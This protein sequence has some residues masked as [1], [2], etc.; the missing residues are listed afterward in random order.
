MRLWINCDGLRAGERV[1][2]GNRRVLVGRILVDDRDV[3]LA[4]IRNVNQFFRRIPSQG[5]NARAVLDG[6]HDFA[7]VRINDHGRIVAT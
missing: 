3:A 7:R 1:D 6:R 2:R 4:A 5:V